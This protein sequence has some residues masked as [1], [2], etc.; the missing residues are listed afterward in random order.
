MGYWE[1][2]ARI[3]EWPRKDGNDVRDIR[4]TSSKRRRPR[5]RVRLRL[6]KPK[7]RRFS[8]DA[9]SVGHAQRGT[10]HPQAKALRRRRRPHRPRSGLGAA[11]P[12]P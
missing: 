12:R 8:S 6:R 3:V 2:L 5:V 7:A 10:A 11:G 4:T 1:P 9:T